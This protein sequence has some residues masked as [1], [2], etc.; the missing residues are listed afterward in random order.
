MAIG[1]FCRQSLWRPVARRLLLA[2]R[3]TQQRSGPLPL[4]AAFVSRRIAG[5]RRC[6]GGDPSAAKKAQRTH[7][8]QSPFPFAV[9]LVLGITTLLQMAAENSI[10]IFFNVYMDDGLGASTTMIGGLTGRRPTTSRLHRISRTGAQP[11][12]RPDPRHHLWRGGDGAVPPPVGDGWP[13]GGSWRDKHGAD[14]L[15]FH[16]PFG[17]Y[18]LPA[19]NG[20]RTLAG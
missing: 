20:R 3:F 17:V 7:R 14:H 10:R 5:Q 8:Q 13:L 11:T 6:H 1:R 18:R 2:A 19:G 12:L 16:P 9:I 15:Q 4:P